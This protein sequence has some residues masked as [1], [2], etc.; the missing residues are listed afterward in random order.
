MKATQSK[1]ELLIENAILKYNQQVS[2]MLDEKLQ[3][4]KTS[5]DKLESHIY[6]IEDRLKSVE[7][8]VEPL[9]KLRRNIWIMIVMVAIVTSIT[10][11]RALNY[12]QNLIK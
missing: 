5:Y 1:E 3:P 9:T 4:I 6:S 10:S 2:K 7:Q 11:D 8:D 12:I